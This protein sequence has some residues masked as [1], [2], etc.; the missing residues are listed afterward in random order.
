M[1]VLTA[2]SHK[3][4]TGKT[5]TLLMLTSAIE[6]KGRSALLIDCDPHQS[7]GAFKAHSV[8]EDADLWSERFDLLYLPYEA[9]TLRHLEAQLLTADESGKYDYALVNLSGTDHPFNRHV[10]RYAEL[11]LLPFAPSAL[12]LMELPA[13][14]EVIR[15]LGEEGEIGAARVVFT[16]MRARMNAAQS[17]YI[18]AALE[19]FPVLGTQIRETA[20]NGDL[21]MRGL[22]GKRITYL[23]VN[24]SGLQRSGIPRYQEALKDC[25]TLLDEVDATIAQQGELA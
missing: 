13:A 6:A 2:Y 3:G 1:K 16:K 10:L 22:L 20:I 5:T 19:G 18:E 25:I 21:V 15:A 4:G 7:F 11:T 9:T 14:L 12:D 23:E 8:T 24:A 17:A